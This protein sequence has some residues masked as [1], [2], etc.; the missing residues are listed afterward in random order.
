MDSRSLQAAA[1]ELEASIQAVIR[2]A[3]IT[4]G[5]ARGRVA[6]KLMKAISTQGEDYPIIEASADPDNLDDIIFQIMVAGH[7]DV[8]RL[9]TARIIEL[10]QTEPN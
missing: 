6:M 10:A 1:S 4:D 5:D 2:Q 7:P 3:G 8:I 9:D